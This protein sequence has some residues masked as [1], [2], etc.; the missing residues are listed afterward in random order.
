MANE[1]RKRGTVW[2]GYPN[3]L[4][5]VNYTEGTLF[6]QVS[7]SGGRIAADPDAVGPG[8]DGPLGGESPT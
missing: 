7:I 5:N 3:V 2:S 1:M 4:Y 8:A 6:R